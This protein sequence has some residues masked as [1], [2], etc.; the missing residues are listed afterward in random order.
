MIRIVTIDKNDILNDPEDAGNLLTHTVKR[1]I[2]MQF[3]G[4]NA[5]PDSPVLTIFLEKTETD[6]PEPAKFVFSPLDSAADDEIAA[7]V[8]QRYEAGFSTLAV[9][10]IADSLWGLFRKKE[11]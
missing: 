7:L 11:S 1:K 2:P 10:R 8:S 4:L 6:E 9:F 3:M 5:D